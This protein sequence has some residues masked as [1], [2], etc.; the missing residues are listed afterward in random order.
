[1][2][3][4]G[5]FLNPLLKVLTTVA[6]LG[7]VYLFILK[8]ALDTTEAIV[9]KT[10]A[11]FNEALRGSMEQIDQAVEGANVPFS[12]S[13]IKREVKGLTPRQARRLSRC[14]QRA[15]PDTAAIEGCFNRHG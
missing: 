3:G 4:A 1:M 14:V 11:P 8:P 5:T 7:A 13:E 12:E 9:D 15:A 2:I 10:V 6:I